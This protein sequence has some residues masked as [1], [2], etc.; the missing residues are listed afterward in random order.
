MREENFLTS[1]KIIFH[2]F[3]SFAFGKN[4]PIIY[5]KYPISCGVWWKVGCLHVHGFPMDENYCSRL[6]STSG[7]MG[8]LVCIG[9]VCNHREF[10][11]FIHLYMHAMCVYIGL[12]TVLAGGERDTRDRSIFKYRNH[13]FIFKYDSKH[14]AT[15][16]KYWLIMVGL[17]L[18]A[19]WLANPSPVQSCLVFALLH[20]IAFS[21]AR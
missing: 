5:R 10:L 19:S 6:N 14:Y 3:H 1:D 16:L 4:S 11:S 15:Y 9:G 12:L 8:V 17:Q 7:A 18:G 21:V 13:G 20:S 2:R